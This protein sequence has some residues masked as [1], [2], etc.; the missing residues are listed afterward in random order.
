MPIRTIITTLLALAPLVGASAADLSPGHIEDLVTCRSDEPI[1]AAA[2]RAH[3]TAESGGQFKVTEGNPFFFT[4]LDQE[5]RLF[6]FPLR[7]VGFAGVE[8]LLGLSVAIEGTPGEVRAALYGR[9][10][11]SHE[12]RDAGCLW[13]AG[14]GMAIFVGPHP[15]QPDLT[16]VMCAVV[17][18]H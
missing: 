13:D 3:L 2:E 14:G 5:A 11:G 8:M 6:G 17:P 10:T 18:E 4:P 7:Y 9:T 12:C 16:I 1:L 15:A